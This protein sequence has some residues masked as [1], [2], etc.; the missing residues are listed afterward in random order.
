VAK[1]DDTKADK[2]DPKADLTDPRAGPTDVDE[3]GALPDGSTVFLSQS[4][5][6][7]FR[8]PGAVVKAGE[9]EIETSPS[10]KGALY[11]GENVV[12][13]SK[14]KNFKADARLVDTVDGLDP[15]S[16]NFLNDLGWCVQNM[17]ATTPE[18]QMLKSVMVK[19]LTGMAGPRL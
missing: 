15:E 14:P 3:S 10:P 18:T 4:G 2:I 19:L 7:S 16:E 12:A 17:P 13:I 6:A 1:K 8:I 5:Q 11:S 9:R